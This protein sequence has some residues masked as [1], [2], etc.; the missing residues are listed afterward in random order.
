MEKKIK[1]L[2]EQ[3]KHIEAINAFIPAAEAEALNKVLDTGVRYEIRRGVDG[4]KTHKHC[5]KTQYFH[6]AMNRMTRRAG[7]RV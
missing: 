6:E 4:K 3:E 2:T 5:F 7:L 1:E